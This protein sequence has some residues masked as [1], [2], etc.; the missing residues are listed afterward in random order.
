MG[1]IFKSLN[2]GLGV[3]TIYN[4]STH[5]I[6]ANVNMS[7]RPNFIFKFLQKETK[8]KRFSSKH[9]RVCLEARLLLLPDN[10]RRNSCK[11]STIHLFYP[12][13]LIAEHHHQ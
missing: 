4:F 1:R 3:G 10:S 12:L 2:H 6:S 5:F 8:W 11:L 9:P 7:F 13:C